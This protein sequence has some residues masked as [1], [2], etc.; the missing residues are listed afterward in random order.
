MKIKVSAQPQNNPF[1]NVFR[2]EIGTYFGDADGYSSYEMTATQEQIAQRLIEIVMVDN[3]FT[4]R[5]GC[6]RMYDQ[7]NYFVEQD[8][9]Y[10]SDV[11]P[12][13]YFDWLDPEGG[14]PYYYDAE[15]NHSIDN[16]TVTW[17]DDNGS[18]FP[19]EV[20]DFSD[21]IA[22]LKAL[23]TKHHVGNY[24]MYDSDDEMANELFASYRK[25]AVELVKKHVAL[26][27]FV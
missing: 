14:F 26:T 25:D 4:G 3:Q 20:S 22:D 2:I 24:N 13:G 9:D 1:R 12:D 27:Q 7:S 18:P 23:N 5:G 16:Y 21:V 17:F 10:D 19:V 8:I 6:R 11:E 15:Q